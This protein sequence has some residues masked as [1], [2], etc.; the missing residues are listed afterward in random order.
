M[1][2]LYLILYIL[3]TSPHCTGGWTVNSVWVEPSHSTLHLYNRTVVHLEPTYITLH[4]YS[5]TV[6]H[7]YL[8]SPPKSQVSSCTAVLM[9]SRTAALLYCCTVYSCTLVLQLCDCTAVHVEASY[10]TAVYIVLQWNCISL[11]KLAT[12]YY[13]CTVQCSVQGSKYSFW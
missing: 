13:R 4:L 5:S 3:P 2:A 12:F 11:L 8:W 6:A 7:L 10:S 1:L 9:Y